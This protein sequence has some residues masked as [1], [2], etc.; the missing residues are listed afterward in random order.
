MGQNAIPAAYSHV[1][2]HSLLDRG[3]KAYFAH[4]TRY[5]PIMQMRFR[6]KRNFC[7]KSGKVQMVSGVEDLQ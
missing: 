4:S 2:M 1:L 6:I 5:V 3:C 7:G